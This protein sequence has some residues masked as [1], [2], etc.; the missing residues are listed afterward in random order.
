[1]TPHE[2]QLICEARE[3]L[4]RYANQNPIISS[5]RELEDY[6]Q[7]V[8]ASSKVE[9]FHVL[10]LDN[11]NRLIE[12]VCH[13]TGT[14]DHVPVYPREIIKQALLLDSSALILTHNHPS[15][16]PTPSRQDI[17][18]TTKVVEAAQTIGITV[19]DHVIVGA[20]HNYS[21]RSN[22]DGLDISIW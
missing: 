13:N 10:Y 4:A 21:M 12:D 17:H 6:L 18:M 11:R 7:L 22:P 16:D 8:Y 20:N 9:K 14:V 19:H 3:I 2:R 5:W 15:G 1:M